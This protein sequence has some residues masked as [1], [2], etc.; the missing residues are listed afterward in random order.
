LDDESVDAVVVAQA[1]HWFADQD[2]LKEIH[3]VI[4]L[5]GCL[6]MVWNIEDYNQTQNW[7]KTTKWETRL[8]DFLWSFDDDAPRFR[9]E[10]WRAVFENQVKTTPF[11]VTA[12]ANPLFSLPLGEEQVKWTVWLSKESI[13]KRYG[14][15]SQ[16]AILEGEDLETA[17]KVFNEALA[18]DDVETNEKGEIAL[19]GVTYLFW[20]SKVPE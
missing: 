19:H 20:T 2:A 11:T 9:N 12:L 7:T 18:G 15:L 17:K 8:N 13:W 1:F 14:T 16:I 5:D 6:G 10:K 3:R 4:R